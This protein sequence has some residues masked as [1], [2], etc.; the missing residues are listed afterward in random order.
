MKRLVLLINF[1]I[2]TISTCAQ[3]SQYDFAQTYFGL[4]TDAIGG[5]QS[6]TFGA[7]RFLI[8]GTHFWQKADFYVSFPLFS[9]RLDGDDWDYSEG[10]I[11][12]FRYLPFGFSRNGPRPFIGGQWITPS[13]RIG[14]GPEYENSRF[15]LEGGLNMA[16][17]SLYT[18]ELSGHYLFNNDAFYPTSRNKNAMVQAPEYGISLA[19]KKY[20]DT[21]SSLKSP[22]SKA[23]VKKR[24]D[25]F[26]QRGSLST[27]NVA[28]GVSANVTLSDLEFLSDYE[29]MPDRPPLSV[30]PDVAVGYYFNELDAG[31]RASWRPMKLSDNAYGFEYELRQ[32]RLALEGFKFL[33]DYKGFA[34][35]LGFSVGNDF[36]NTQV[37][38]GELPAM[39]DSQSVLSYGIT[40]GWD[41]RPT[42]TQS[43]ILRTNLRYIVQGSDPGSMASVTGNHLEI[44]FIQ[45]VIYPSRWK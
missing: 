17:G 25:E 2:W 11:T 6:P 10:V 41:I 43:T 27:W 26:G 37:R 35:F 7:A 3:K 16:F 39:T 1:V 18:L 21:T 32:Q 19:V 22:E 13:L 30:Y 28:I 15:G 24:Y 45:M 29:F 20:M 23:Y 40:F 34:P 9:A 44:N 5:G 36:I 38:D 4:Q 42:K 8:G 33:F 14:D 31:I 12:G